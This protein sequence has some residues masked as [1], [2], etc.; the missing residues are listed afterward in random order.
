VSAA[1]ARPLHGSR[2]F[3]TVLDGRGAPEAVRDPRGFAVKFYT[4][5]GNY[6]KTDQGIATFTTEEAA[7]LA[8][9]N[10][11]SHNSDLVEAIERGDYPSW[12]LK[13][14]I[15]PAT[16]ATD[17]RINPFDL[18]KV[19]PHADCPLVEVGKLALDRNADNYGRDGVMR[20]DANGGRSKNYEP[21]SF[22][23]PVQT[24]EPHYAGLASEGISGTYEW[25]ERETD[26]FEQAGAARRDRRESMSRVP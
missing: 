22:D 13:V 14:Q 25:N 17:Y 21:N 10:P 5:G 4:P 16:D 9:A 11:E 24:N 1:G 8:G 26:D 2:R 20:V 12:T 19:W 6:F 7:A 23:G 3:S 15:M 18:T